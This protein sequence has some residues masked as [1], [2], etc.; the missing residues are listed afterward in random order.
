MR[1]PCRWQGALWLA[2]FFVA[3]S[4][5]QGQQDPRIGYVYPAGG[6]PGTVVEV[7]LGGQYLNGVTAAY[8]TGSG[9]QARVIGYY[10]PLSQQEAS[11]LSLKVREL[12]AR[13]RERA[14]K[15]LGKKRAMKSGGYYGSANIYKAAMMALGLKLDY[16]TYRKLGL[17][18]A[19]PKRQPN[20]QLDETVLL[21]ITLAADAKPGTRELRLKTARGISNPLAFRVGQC[22][23]YSEKEPNDKRADEGLPKWLPVV[24]NGQIMPGDVDCFRF[25]ANKGTRLVAAVS[26]RSL[27]PYLADAVPGWFQA[28]LT[29]YDGKGDEVAYVDD[30]RF[31]PDPVIY[32]EV[33]ESGE[34]VLEIKDAI[35]RGREDFVYRITLGELPF[36]TSIFPLGG[37]AGAK[38]TVK[39]T[40]WNLSTDRLTVD[41]KGKGAGVLPVSVPGKGRVSN[42]VPFA[43]DTLPECLE[44]EPNDR[45]AAAQK[46]KVPQIVNGRI[47]RPG[48]WDV[49]SFTGRA[50]QQIVAE[51]QA[52]RLGSPVDSLLKLANARGKQ[53][54][55]ND[56][57]KDRGAGL[58][59][60]HADSRLSVKLPANGTYLLYLG[61]TQNKGGPAYAY[62]LRISPRQP[63]FALRVVPSN[64]NASVGATVPITVYALWKDEF[65]GDITLRLKDAPQGL[66]LSGGWIPAGQEKVRL[67][68]TFPR[69][70]PKKPL[71]LHLEGVATLGG[72]EVRRMAVPAEDM[73]QAFIY[74]HLVPTENWTAYLTGRRSY[75]RPM[76]LLETEPVK[77]PLGGT[78]RVVLSSPKGRFVQQLRLVLSKPPEGIAIEKVLPDPQGVAI[79]LS[80][81]GKKI[82]P[83]LKGNLIVEAFQEREIKTKEGKPTGRT[84]RSA[85]GTLPAIPFEIVPGAATKPAKP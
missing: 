4:G 21:Y 53:L 32:Y 73:T 41:A 30:F 25:T 12:A 82:K 81:G 42:R 43:L 55:V 24:V 1:S 6:R 77:L 23:E 83:A 2:T 28:A 11:D 62:R 3:V 49:F 76:R 66:T 19:N 9:V 7:S 10:K 8:I 54:A 22:Q 38:T 85:L 18:L 69:T 61:D 5:A 58:T 50:G 79:V 13:Q 57:H 59:T 67:T 63:D 78:A 34:Y 71:N 60:H 31:H 16:G 26:A 20:A 39:V 33:P 45:R 29:L 75:R 48:D 51:V 72:Q 52:R 56:D 37:P 15:K 35:Y 36:V 70:A 47:D 80:A 46:L 64:I 84:Y 68:L 27:I 44:T 14:I 40:G 17:K 74:H 65:S